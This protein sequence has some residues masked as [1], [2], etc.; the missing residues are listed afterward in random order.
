MST[1]AARTVCF[2]SDRTGVTT[3]TVGHSLLSRFSGF[4]FVTVTMPFVSNVT[5]A[6]GVV[7]RIDAL[8]AEQHA[9]PIVF[10]TIVDPETRAVITRANALVIDLFSTFVA[11][12]E[13]EL[14]ARAE[15]SGVPA[16]H[17]ATTDPT[18]GARIEATNYALANDDGAGARDYRSANVVLL[19]VSRSGKTP[20]CLYLALQYGVLAANYPLAEE[21]LESGELP[22]ALQPHRAKLYGLTVKAD[23]LQ[24]IRSERRPGSRYAS[25]Q[26][27]QYELRAAQAL[28]ARYSVPS[29]DVT[30]CSIE[31]IASRIMDEMALAR[32]ARS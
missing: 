20:T 6:Q 2:V 9:K 11:Q 5:Q 32:H 13:S 23:R 18:Y 14:G 1:G 8:G 7:A 21:E 10:C 29:L 27:V 3:E 25:A 16:M 22:R 4:S 28:Y 24:Q 26:Q 30:E 17:G 12:L 15:S 31:E 19:G